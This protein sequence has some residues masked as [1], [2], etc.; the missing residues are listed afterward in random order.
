M[1]KFALMN[2]LKTT[3]TKTLLKKVVVLQQ[4]I[5]QS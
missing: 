2:V 4:E 3:L 5:S 1:L